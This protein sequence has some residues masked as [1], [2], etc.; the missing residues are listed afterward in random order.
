MLLISDAVSSVPIFVV[1]NTLINMLQY[2][3]QLT[4]QNAHYQPLPFRLE[5]L[6]QIIYYPVVPV[7]GTIVNHVIFQ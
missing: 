4:T 5:C 2:L 7:V 6:H 1:P 3:L